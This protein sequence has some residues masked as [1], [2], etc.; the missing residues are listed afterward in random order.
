MEKEEM[1]DVELLV[2]HILKAS[3]GCPVLAN[4]PNHSAEINRA[5]MQHAIRKIGAWIASGRRLEIEN[6]P[7]RACVL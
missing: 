5:C 2:E 4:W 3:C 6:E 7:E 1:I